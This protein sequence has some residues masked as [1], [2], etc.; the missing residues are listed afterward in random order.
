MSFI[1]LNGDINSKAQGFLFAAT[2]VA[3]PE[4]IDLPNRIILC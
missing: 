2:K 1:D 3:G 4:P